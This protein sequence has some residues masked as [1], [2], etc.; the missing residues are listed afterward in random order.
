MCYCI[1]TTHMVHIMNGFIVA[2]VVLQCCSRSI[3]LCDHAMEW[4]RLHEWSRHHVLH[5]FQIPKIE[6]WKIRPMLSNEI[7]LAC[8]DHGWY[9]SDFAR[10]CIVVWCVLVGGGNAQST[11][12]DQNTILAVQWMLS[13]FTGNQTW[14][15]DTPMFKRQPGCFL[16]QSKGPKSF[17]CV[18][19]LCAII[20]LASTIPAF[21]LGC[22]CAVIILRAWRL[23]HDSK[24]LLQEQ[25]ISLQSNDSWQW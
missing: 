6:V 19:H 2:S 3:L 9:D 1:R 12:Q 18:V 11:H 25:Q 17:D 22:S 20:R 5:S 16:P 21:L 15:R 10:A 13:I 4:I 23:T 24:R 14:Q 7:P 8:S